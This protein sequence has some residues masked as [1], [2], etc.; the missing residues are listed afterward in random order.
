MVTARMHQLPSG[1]AAEWC[2]TPVRGHGST[3]TMR[4]GAGWMLTCET[5][6]PMT[7]SR[8]APA[9]TRGCPGAVAGAAATA[10]PAGVGA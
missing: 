4:G 3:I 5:G 10:T 7:S 9:G 6:W 1:G 8:D 2:G